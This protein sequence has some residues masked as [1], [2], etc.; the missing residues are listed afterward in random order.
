MREQLYI[1]ICS[2]AISLECCIFVS[3]VE[4]DAV[5]RCLFPKLSEEFEVFQVG[6]FQM[7]VV[8]EI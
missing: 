2:S 6:W 3:L 5:L 7:L 8:E 4:V 1:Y